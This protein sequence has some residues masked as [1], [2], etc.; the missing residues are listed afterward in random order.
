MPVS[1][2]ALTTGSSPNGREL[3]FAVEQ[4]AGMVMLPAS[5]SSTAS[6]LGAPGV[7]CR[8]PVAP[9]VMLPVTAFSTASLP[10]LPV[11]ITDPDVPPADTQRE[12]PGAVQTRDAVPAPAVTVASAPAVATS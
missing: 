3:Q 5:A 1:E 7:S 4:L 8:L 10:A 11:R 6:P 9:T 12:V 2:T